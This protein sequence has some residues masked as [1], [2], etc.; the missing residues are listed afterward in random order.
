MAFEI[1]YETE[2]AAAHAIVLPDGSLEPVHGHN[3]SVAVTVAADTLDAIETVMDFHDLERIVRGITAE[4]HNKHLNECA[5]FVSADHGNDGALHRHGLAI[6]PTAERVAE[7][8][9]KTTAAGLPGHVCLVSAAVGEA[10]G[11]IAR[12][13]PDTHDSTQ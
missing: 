4:W 2:F 5:P 11:C 9:G 12:Y 8:I 6:S 3:W 13:R 10:P 1:V 7:H